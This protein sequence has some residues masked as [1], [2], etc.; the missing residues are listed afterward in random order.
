MSQA[1]VVRCS[2]GGKRSLAIPSP[3]HPQRCAPVCSRDMAI[4]TSWETLKSSSGHNHN[5]CLVRPPRSSG[6]DRQNPEDRRGPR[7]LDNWRREADGFIYCHNCTVPLKEQWESSVHLP[8]NQPAGCPR[9]QMASSKTSPC[10]RSRFLHN[11]NCSSHDTF[12]P[13]TR[14]IVDS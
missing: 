2:C 10:T 7:E 5:I 6:H 12:V 13:G 8:P 11:R 4:G 14:D 1:R 9:F 3:P